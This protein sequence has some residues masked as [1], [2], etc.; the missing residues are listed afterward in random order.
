MPVVEVVRT[1]L[2]MRSSAALRP[3]LLPDVV[4]DRAGTPAPVALAREHPCA[5]STYRALYSDVG[6]AYHWRDRLDWSDDVLS[7]Y[8]ARETVHVWILRA[9]GAPA[10]YFELVAHDDRSV[11]IAYFGL[12]RAWL[13]RGL[14]K[15][16]LTRAASEAWRLGAERVWLHTCTL[17]SPAALPNYVARGFSPYRSERYSTELPGGHDP[18]APRDPAADQR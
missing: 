14:G 2:E 3:A 12:T 11:E 17:D 7:A 9:G 18:D 15:G 4:A 10:G 8:L 6:G 5:P 13:G 16:M 1:Y